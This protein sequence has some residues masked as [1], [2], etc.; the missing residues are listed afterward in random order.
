[1]YNV[2]ISFA[3]SSQWQF[4]FHD[5]ETAR[6][7]LRKYEEHNGKGET[8]T[9]KDDFGNEAVILTSVVNG[10]IV[11]DMS[12]CTDAAVERT[13]LQA[14]GQAKAQSRAQA[15]PALRILGQL[16]GPMPHHMRS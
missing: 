6:S 4:L 12:K 1:M 7:V 15:D 2:M 10:I 9:V 8:F 16:N 3:G 14:R 13:L 11:E 5:K